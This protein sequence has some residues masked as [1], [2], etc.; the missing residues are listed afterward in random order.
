MKRLLGYLKPFRLRITIGLSVK[1]IGTIMD[2]FLPWILSYI[3]DTVIPTKRINSIIFWGCMM[4]VCSVCALTFNIVANR[5]ASFVSSR[6]TRAIRHD[7][8]AKISYLDAKQLDRFT[9]SSLE[10][11][12]TSDTYNIHKMIGMLQRLGIRAPIF[13]IGGITITFLLD[14]KLTL[15]LVCTMPFIA[16]TI[17]IISKKGIRL[18]T[19][20]QQA[21]DN[22]TCVIRENAAGVRVIKA[23]RRGEYEKRRFDKSNINAIKKEK[24]VGITMALTNPLITLFLNIGL[25]A[26]IAVGAYLVNNGQSTNGKIIAFISY[27]TIISNAMISISRMFAIVSKGSAGMG[28]ID[29]VL[30]CKPT[31]WVREP[32]SEENSSEPISFDKPHIE[33]KNVTFAYNDV[34]I[35]ENIS[36]S[37]LHGQT[38]GIIGPTGSG[39]S[40][41]ISLLNRTYDVGRGEILIDG[42]NIKR[43]PTKKLSEKFGFVFQ[44]D[45]FFADTI[46]ENI[47]FG[48]DLSDEEISLALKRAQA[49]E[50]V[51]AYYDGILHRLDIKGANISG[52]QKQ[53]LLIARAL[54]A[55]PEILVLDDSSSALDF[56]TDAA[57]RAEISRSMKDTTT[58]IIT[59]RISSI[60]NADLI[61]VL[62]GGRI[63]GMGKHSELLE[64][65]PEY[66]EISESQMGGCFAL[67]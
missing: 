14:V 33:F 30:S 54:A 41:L 11:R 32:E 27:F 37:L 21:I 23:L 10:S 26:V 67:E 22:M 34:N 60:M 64:S 66:R 48:R 31:L 7:L 50:F 38:L 24:A 29:K 46:R 59:Q 63:S 18:F 62:S 25:C 17:I 28:R 57:L 12:L 20:L 44:N 6:C 13:L 56:K 1:F 9:V 40:T 35:I 65:C 15:V 5:M 42:R 47:N 2:L 58:I 39:K 19:L 61:L 36:F 49:S 43:I 45:F 52:G 3:I 4:I 8:Y 51:N 53:R 55:N 16:L